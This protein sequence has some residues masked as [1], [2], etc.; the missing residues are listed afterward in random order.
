MGPL[1]NPTPLALAEVGDLLLP[2][3]LPVKPLPP[4]NPSPLLPLPVPSRRAAAVKRPVLL[5]LPLLTDDVCVGLSFKCAK[6]TY[7]QFNYF[8]CK[9]LSACTAKNT[10]FERNLLPTPIG[11]LPSSLTEG[12]IDL[13]CRMLTKH[14]FLSLLLPHFATPS[15][16]INNSSR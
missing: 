5:E 10:R 16:H 6:V 11:I 7:T 15:F 9:Q 2:L 13:R 8:T 4:P 14:S 3:S 1:L 12:I